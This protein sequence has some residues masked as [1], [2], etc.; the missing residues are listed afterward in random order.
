[1]KQ[2]FESLPDFNYSPVPF[3]DF[4]KR[5]FRPLRRTTTGDFY[6]GCWSDATNKRDGF[7]YCI[8][9]ESGYLYEGYWSEGN[10]HGPGRIILENG[11]YV[12]QF[13]MNQRHG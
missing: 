10:Q 12:G 3:I 9:I 1:M 6:E 2:I 11:Y 8:A 7:G 5:S 13:S 4:C